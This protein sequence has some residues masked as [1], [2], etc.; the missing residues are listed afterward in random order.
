MVYTK[1]DDTVCEQPSYVTK[2]TDYAALS[3]RGA[4]DQF[5]QLQHGLQNCVM[6]QC[7]G[8][9]RQQAKIKAL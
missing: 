3:K 2:G 9:F 8:S 5:G 6:Q 7:G 1:F 4:Q